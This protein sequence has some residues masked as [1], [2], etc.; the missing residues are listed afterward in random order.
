M[1]P[2]YLH[3]RHFTVAEAIESLYV[4]HP[5]IERMRQLAITLNKMDFDYLLGEYT[6]ENDG[7]LGKLPPQ[8]YEMLLQVLAN[9]ENAGII[10]KGIEEGLVDF[11]HL[12][13]GGEEVYLCYQIGEETIH[14]WHPLETGYAGRKPLSE[15]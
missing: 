5:L 4:N 8:E 3:T 6:G 9:L 7:G 1:K 14:F 15:L 2:D 12:R 10:V 13:Q 11:P